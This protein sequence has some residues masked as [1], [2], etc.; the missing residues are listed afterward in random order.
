MH[1][2]INGQNKNIDGASTVEALVAHFCSNSRAIITELNG[3]IIPKTDWQ[4]TSL[5][6]GDTVEL[7]SFVGGG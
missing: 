6:D 4:K 7:V 3:T 1:L 5:K 2:T